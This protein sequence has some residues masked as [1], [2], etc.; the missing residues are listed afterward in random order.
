MGFKMLYIPKKT[1]DNAFAAAVVATSCYLAPASIPFIASAYFANFL[2]RCLVGKLFVYNKISP[3]NA[4]ITINCLNFINVCTCTAKYDFQPLLEINL[5]MS[6]TVAKNAALVLA[7]SIAAI[8]DKYS[9]V[10]GQV[11]SNLLTSPYF[12]G[13]SAQR[14][15]T[16]SFLY[17]KSFLNRLVAQS[18]KAFF[19]GKYEAFGYILSAFT[20]T[21]LSSTSDH[22]IF[23]AL[24]KS[25]GLIVA[26]T[27]LNLCEDFLDTSTFAPN[28]MA[29]LAHDLT[30]ELWTSS[31]AEY[32]IKPTCRG[33]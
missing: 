13:N 30:K 2:T 20:S 27:L 33:T 26:K 22:L 19:D 8:Q 3:Q 24:N 7:L 11:L 18:V 15:T 4:K 28:F 12:D 10:F 1:L 9:Q 21:Y 5:T 14:K 6:T 32:V 31:I 17:S 23:T 29:F 16:Q 25:V